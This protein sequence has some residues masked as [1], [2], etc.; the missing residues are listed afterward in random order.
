MTCHYLFLTELCLYYLLFPSASLVCLSFTH[1][2]PFSFIPS[3]ARRNVSGSFD[4]ILPVVSYDSHYRP[5]FNRY[6]HNSPS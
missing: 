6:C 2:C 5:A 4:A 3:L 1:F